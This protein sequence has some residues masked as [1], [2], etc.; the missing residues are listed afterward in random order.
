MGIRSIWFG[1]TLSLKATNV[2]AKPN[3]PCRCANSA[4]SLIRL[5]S[6]L[7]GLMYWVH[8]KPFKSTLVAKIKRNIEYWWF[9][10]NIMQ[11]FCTWAKFEL[12]SGQWSEFDPTVGHF[13]EN[14]GFL[15]SNTL[16]T[17]FYEAGSR[18]YASV[19]YPSLVQTIACPFASN[20]PSYIPMLEYCQWD[21]YEKKPSVT[22]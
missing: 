5:I 2:A 12:M 3:F 20:N 18:I 11:S 15:R 19:N 4:L 1:G 21:L 10:H 7:G 6:G 9:Y 13:H 17:L 16:M 22:F 8:P 14:H